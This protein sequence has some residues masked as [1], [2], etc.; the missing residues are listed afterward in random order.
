MHLAKHGEEKRIR[1]H[2]DDLLGTPDTLMMI[3]E[4]EPKKESILVRLTIKCYAFMKY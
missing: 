4:E 2:L 1:S 3:D